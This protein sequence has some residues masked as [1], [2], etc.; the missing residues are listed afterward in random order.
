[1]YLFVFCVACLT[2]FLI[3]LVKQFVIL[4]GVEVILLL[5]V[6]EVLSVG[7]GVLLDRPCMVF[8]RMCVLYLGS[9]YACRCSFHKFSSVCVCRKLSSHLGVRE[10]DHMSLLTPCYFLC[11][12]A[13]YVVG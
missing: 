5:N 9:Q 12:F 8:Q 1:M 13:Y 3:Y 6:R 4:L 7:G 10:L 2:V 11:D